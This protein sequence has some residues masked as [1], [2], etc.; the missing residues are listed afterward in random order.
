MNSISPA[1]VWTLI[2]FLL[3]S[4]SLISVELL[5]C[6]CIHLEDT[7]GVVLIPLDCKAFH[8]LLIFIGEEAVDKI[9]TSGHFQVGLCSFFPSGSF[10]PTLCLGTICWLYV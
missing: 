9:Q 5:P 6:V 1:S 8:C 4:L 10:T 7:S 3:F 2:F